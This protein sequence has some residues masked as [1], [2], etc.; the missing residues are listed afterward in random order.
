V[1]LLVIIL[2]IVL[3]YVG[4]FGSAVTGARRDDAVR[5][6]GIFVGVVGAVVFVALGFA[7]WI[8]TSAAV[9]YQGWC[10]NSCDHGPSPNGAW[11]AADL[12]LASLAVAAALSAPL[13]LTL[14]RERAAFV[15]CALAAACAVAWAAWAAWG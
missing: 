14:R 2:F 3:P 5:G 11:I 6:L 4:F 7:A 9:T 12:A 13:L 10:E 1:A 15:A 8:L